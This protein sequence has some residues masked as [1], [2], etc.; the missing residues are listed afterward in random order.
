MNKLWISGMIISGIMAFAFIY[1]SGFVKGYKYVK[2]VEDA[3]V[4]IVPGP[5]IEII[6]KGNIIEIKEIDPP[7]YTEE[8]LLFDLNHLYDVDKEEKE[9]INRFI[10]WLFPQNQE[11]Q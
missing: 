3:E 5:G 4:K 7:C 2:D 11:I 10:N 1:A 9:V 6:E 8:K